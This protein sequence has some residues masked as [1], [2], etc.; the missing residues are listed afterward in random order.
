[1]GACPSPWGRNARLIPMTTLPAT[2]PPR[3]QAAAEVAAEVREVK[4]K[5]PVD[6]VLRLHYTRIKGGQNFSQIVSSA[7]SRYFQDLQR[8]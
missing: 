1:M 5:L 7:L 4:V 3:T 2:D 6:Q 8:P